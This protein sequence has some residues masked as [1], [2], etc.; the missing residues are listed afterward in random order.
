MQT[1]LFHLKDGSTSEVERSKEIATCY[2]TADGR[3]LYIDP[4]WSSVATVLDIETGKKK[5]RK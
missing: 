2:G 4:L 3:F 5:V 1:M